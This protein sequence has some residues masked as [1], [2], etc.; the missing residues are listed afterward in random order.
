ML[1]WEKASRLVYKSVC[2]GTKNMKIKVFK[3]TVALISA[4]LIIFTQFALSSCE[5]NSSSGTEVAS[6]PSE[7][8]D[9]TSA[10]QYDRDESLIE[11]EDNQ[12]GFLL[13]RDI[14]DRQIDVNN[15]QDAIEVLGGLGAYFDDPE[16]TAHIRLKETSQTLD[17]T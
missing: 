4:I 10:E 8:H 9:S 3:R 2:V 11:E 13:V 16:L 1:H 6:K 5:S 14:S 7:S 12:H 15:E 17:S